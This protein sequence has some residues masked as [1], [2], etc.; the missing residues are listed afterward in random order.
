M[1]E[2]LCIFIAGYYLNRIIGFFAVI[3]LSIIFM[4]IFLYRL[5]QRE[6]PLSTLIRFIKLKFTKKNNLE[7]SN[8]E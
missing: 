3:P 7:K 8:D 1:I 2:I 5:E 4:S 6:F